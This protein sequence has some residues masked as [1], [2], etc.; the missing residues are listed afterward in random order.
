VIDWNA[1]GTWA[2]V[3]VALGLSLKE[4][5]YRQRE[6]S[7]R[8]L[9]V[10]AEIFPTVSTLCETLTEIRKDA[11]V[12]VNSSNAELLADAN[13]AYKSLFGQLSLEPW[14]PRLEQPDALPEHM[15]IP[16]YKSLTLM[17][18]LSHNFQARA[19]FATLSAD[20]ERAFLSEWIEQ[21]ESIRQSLSWVV[22]HAEK[23][24]ASRRWKYPESSAGH[25]I[26]PESVRKDSN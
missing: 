4:T 11:T 2:A 20:S 3:V 8:H 24:M 10:A 5:W 22:Q 26:L 14:R 12:V 7:T 18:M 23:M 25:A 19:E 16:L 6:R 1:L 17:R 21:G 15:L 13:G 9:L